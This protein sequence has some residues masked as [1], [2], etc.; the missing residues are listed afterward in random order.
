MRRVHLEFTAQIGGPPEVVFDLVADMPNYSRW[1]PDSDAFGGTVG[2]TP[3][4]VRL[5]TKYLD[6]GP[7]EKPGEVTEFDRPRHIGFRHTVMIRRG[8][9]RT[10]IDARIRYSFEARDGGTFVLR[11][12]DLEMNLRGL[13]RLATP[14]VLRSFRAEN[15]RTLAKLKEFVEMNR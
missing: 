6:A 12:L 3:Y 15:V 5:G 8:L 7:I 13:L 9:L 1:L 14:V 10:D 2:V 4:P 11:E